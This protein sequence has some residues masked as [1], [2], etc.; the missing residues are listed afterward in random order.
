MPSSPVGVTPIAIWIA[1]QY[2]FLISNCFQLFLLLAASDTN[3]PPLAEYAAMIFFVLIAA[4]I[5][6]IICGSY[7]YYFP[8]G[9]HI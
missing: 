6:C 4:R 5:L 7:F 1:A 3:V 9:M 8:K 2:P